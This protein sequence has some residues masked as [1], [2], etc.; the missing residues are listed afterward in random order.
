MI[1]EIIANC[2]VPSRPQAC[3]KILPHSIFHLFDACVRLL[4]TEIKTR[5]S[6]LSSYAKNLKCPQGFKKK[7][8]GI[9]SF[10]NSH[11]QA[12]FLILILILILKQQY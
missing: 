7:A 11:R 1:A 5:K 2:D 9:L 8:G 3:Q 12:L 10:P 4:D 6:A